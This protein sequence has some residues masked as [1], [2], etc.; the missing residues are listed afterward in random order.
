MRN[1]PLHWYRVARDRVLDA[2]SQAREVQYVPNPKALINNMKGYDEKSISKVSMYYIGVRYLVGKVS[3]LPLNLFEKLPGGG[4]SIAVNHPLYNVL[5]VKPNRYMTTPEFHQFVIQAIFTKG[6]AYSYIIWKNGNVKELIPLIGRMELKFIISKEFPGESELIYSF[7]PA[8]ASAYDT[9]GSTTV[10]FRAN[11]ILHY[12]YM[13]TDGI[14][15]VSPIAASEGLIKNEAMHTQYDTSFFQQGA[16]VGAVISM[17]VPEDKRKGGVKGMDDDDTRSDWEDYFEERWSGMD[18]SHKI[19]VLPWSFQFEKMNLSPS[20]SEALAGNKYSA[21]KVFAILGLPGSKF[22]VGELK[23]S[24][25]DNADRAVMKDTLNPLLVNMEKRNDVSLLSDVDQGR[26]F[27]QY[28]RSSELRGD[29]KQQAEVEGIRVK[30]GVLLRNEV[31]ANLDLAPIEGGS[32]ATKQMQ[33]EPLS[34][35]E[36]MQKIGYKPPTTKST[37][38]RALPGL[39][40]ETINKRFTPTLVDIMD[41][42]V[43]KEWRALQRKIDQLVVNDKLVEFK[44]WNVEF[45]RDTAKMI[46][47]NVAPT[48]GLFGLALAD[49]EGAD[50]SERLLDTAAL[51]A[52]SRFAE[53]YVAESV[54]AVEAVLASDSDNV[55]GLEDLIEQWSKTRARQFV[56]QMLDNEEKSDEC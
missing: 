7:T 3:A 16:N 46:R 13:S 12:R 41:R 11:E 40:R 21:N 26:Y 15:G 39:T 31:R 1:L 54:E 5:H 17:E 43:V 6:N 42:V 28:N 2:L 34:W 8:N 37:D 36:D 9:F 14:Q 48:M 18:N 32:V 20:D 27:S 29:P 19:A 33:D 23:F 30:S 56:G 49:N 22:N 25:M 53:Q 38:S 55:R 50:V 10:T 47:E 51:M 52:A 44:E 45:N 35:L 24:N 4:S